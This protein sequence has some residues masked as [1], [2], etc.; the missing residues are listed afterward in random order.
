MAKL[1]IYQYP[2]KH[3]KRWQSM[4]KPLF[5]K[6]G[7][8]RRF[9]DLGCN[10]GFYM[11]K[12]IKYGYR[13]V[14]IEKESFYIDR[15]G[16]SLNIIQ[17][18]VNYQEFG[19]Y[20]LVLMSHVHYWQSDEQVEALFH[21]LRYA[22]PKLIV[23]GKHHRRNT[24]T[25]PS[26]E[27]LKNVLKGWKLVK[28]VRRGRYYSALFASTVIKEFDVDMLYESTY[29]WIMKLK[30]MFHFMTSFE[31][32]VK[33]SLDDINFDPKGCDFAEYLRLIKG[34]PHYHLGRC[35]IYK[36]LIE[37]LKANGPNAPLVVVNGRLRD[38]FHRLIILK[39]LG[40]KR[41]VCR[42]NKR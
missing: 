36:T 18:D 32:F 15:A 30:H 25:N 35:W 16:D 24:K 28:E 17:G 41:V 27:H 23:S 21:L 6:D 29:E 39:E 37:D 8:N 2:E 9:L 12:A 26:Y 22:T 38:G 3:E 1:K 10:E 33:R 4:I 40:Y 31:D 5:D 34:K 42:L 11:K 19:C 7:A 20:N 14:G 13:A